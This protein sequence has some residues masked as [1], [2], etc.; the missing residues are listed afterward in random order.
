[1]SDMQFDT[2]NEEFGRPP[3]IQRGDFA[4][5]LVGWGLVGDRQIAIYT[6]IGVGVLALL[7]AFLLLSGGSS[8]APPLL[9]E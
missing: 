5:K 9:P 3:A 2:S 6:L 8:D 7:G 4:D 1:M